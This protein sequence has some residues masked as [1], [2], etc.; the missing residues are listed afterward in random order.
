ME[1][2]PH[3]LPEEKLHEIFGPA[4]W[5]QLPDEVYKRVRVQPAVYT[6]EEHHVAVYA[7]R[8]KGMGIPPLSCM[9]TRKPGKRTIHGNS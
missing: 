8:E 1:V 4:G 6:V 3:T 5:K 7:G 2:I 9:N